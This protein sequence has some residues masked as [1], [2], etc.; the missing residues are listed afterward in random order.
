MSV[1]IGPDWPRIAGVHLVENGDMGA[2]WLACDPISQSVNLYDCGVF[3][4]EV[5]PVLADALNCRGRWIPIAWEKGAKTLSDKLLND[6]GCN[7]LPEPCDDK[8]G[9][10]EVMARDLWGSI[11]AG[12]FRVDDRC[13][14]WMAELDS[15]RFEGGGQLPKEG[16]PLMAAT[17]HAMTMLSYAKRQF[18][19]SKYSTRAPDQ[20]AFV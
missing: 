5:L 19:A 11:R 13:K 12:N 8:T 20:T 17:R 16:F 15:F 7:M 2:V 1:S 6:M 4:Y 9:V 10:A 18:Q 14:D 3:K